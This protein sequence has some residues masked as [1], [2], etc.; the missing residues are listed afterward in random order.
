[1]DKR[2]HLYVLHRLHTRYLGQNHLIGEKGHQPSILKE[3][4][5]ATIIFAGPGVILYDWFQ[6]WTFA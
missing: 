3:N 6:K 2:D 4:V 1:M 5:T